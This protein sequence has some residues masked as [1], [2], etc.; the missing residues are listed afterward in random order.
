MEHWYLVKDNCF[1]EEAGHWGRQ[2][3]VQSNCNVT[4]KYVTKMN[5]IKDKGL[6]SCIGN[7]LQ[8]LLKPEHR[9]EGQLQKS[10]GNMYLYVRCLG[11]L[12][13]EKGGAE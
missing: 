13:F 3:S 10:A 1:R 8:Q 4:P 5:P 2:G 6:S 7:L 9:I 12:G 11:L